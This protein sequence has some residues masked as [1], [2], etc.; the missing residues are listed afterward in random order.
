MFQRGHPHLPLRGT[1][2]LE[3]EGNIHI[4]SPFE[5]EGQGEG[6]AFRM[7]KQRKIP[8]PPAKF[9]GFAQQLRRQQVPAEV[10]LW[11]LLRAQ[12]FGGYKFRRQHPVAPYVLDFYCPQQRLAIELDGS[13]HS[14]NPGRDAKRDEF[15][16]GKGIRVLRFWNEALFN[17]T[18]NAL[19]AIWIALHPESE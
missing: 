11:Y 18:E 4:P 5:G 3:G 1:F 17:E 19:T 2:P 7:S 6:A 9:L 13:Q 8:R 10:L 15:L 16:A 14:E 12:R